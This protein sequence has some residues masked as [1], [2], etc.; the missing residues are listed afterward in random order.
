[1]YVVT[2]ITPRCHIYCCSWLSSDCDWCNICSKCWRNI[3]RTK[4]YK[5]SASRDPVCCVVQDSYGSLH[6]RWI[7][8]VQVVTPYLVSVLSLLNVCVTLPLI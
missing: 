5:T 3:W 7:P 2:A 1:M 6:C 8:T 4:S